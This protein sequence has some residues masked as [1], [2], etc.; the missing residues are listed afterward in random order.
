[1]PNSPKS[2]GPLLERRRLGFK[3]SNVEDLHDIWSFNVRALPGTK[4]ELKAELNAL[5]PNHAG[6]PQLLIKLEGQLEQVNKWAAWPAWR[7][8]EEGG[9]TWTSWPSP[10][11]L[12][13]TIPDRWVVADGLDQPAKDF[14]HECLEFVP[15]LDYRRVSMTLVQTPQADVRGRQREEARQDLSSGMSSSRSYDKC[16]RIGPG[17]NEAQRCGRRPGSD[18]GHAACPP[19]A[20]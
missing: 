8:L 1:M 4:A 16:S 10:K 13:A 20:Q 15:P 17:A 2:V 18:Q 3:P 9:A 5:D 14:E 6:D 19:Y 7:Q 12:N 11:Y